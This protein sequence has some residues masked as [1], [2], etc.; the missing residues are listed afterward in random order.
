MK[1]VGKIE[2]NLISETKALEKVGPFSYSVKMGSLN[3]IP[4]GR[5]SPP[6]PPVEIWG[7]EVKFI[8]SHSSDISS[9]DR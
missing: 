9:S 8:S 6:P 2:I 1:D 5:G 3:P 4:P 7:R